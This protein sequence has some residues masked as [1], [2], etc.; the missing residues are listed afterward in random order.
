MRPTTLGGH[1]SYV[2]VQGTSMEPTYHDGDLVIVREDEHYAIGDIIAFRAGGQFDDPTRV[3]HR[4]VGQADAGAFVTR[5]DNRDSTDPWEPKPDHIIGRAIFHVPRVGAWAVQAGRPEVLAALGGGAVFLGDRKRRRRRRH[6]TATPDGELPRTTELPPRPAR[7]A[8]AIPSRW[9][10]HTEPRWAFVGF[11]ASAL[12]AL[13]LLV[14]TWSAINADDASTKVEHLADIDFGIGFDYRFVGDP[15]TVYPSGGVSTKQDPA[16]LL[17]PTGPLYTRLLHRLELA[18]SFRSGS[19]GTDTLTASY[20]VDVTASMPEGWS[21]SLVAIAPVSFEDST[22]KVLAVDLD[23]VAARVAEVAA[24]TGVDPASYTLTVAPRLEV[25][26]A[27][28]KATASDSLTPQVTFIVNDAVIEAQPMRAA[29]GSRALEREVRTDA[30]YH[31]GPVSVR[32]QAARAVLGGLLLV[33]LA[34]T[35]WFASVLFGGV[36]LA[37]SERIAVRYRSQMVD[38]TVATAPPGPVVMVGAIDELVRLARVEQ[39]V[40]LHEAL[41]DGCHRYRV[42][43]GTVTYEYETVPEHG[44]AA[45]DE[46]PGGELAAPE[47]NQPEP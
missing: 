19:E 12:L 31:V 39:T 27:R 7:P 29:S 10:R 11:V 33:L 35:A 44:G 38:V 45:S 18:M 2:V 15:S 14:G 21:T 16:G 1:E 46:L 34:A 13:P 36:G 22:E 20:A 25:E 26:G 8:T 24:L 6:V 5:G 28:G 42:F 30:R 23:D 41:H 17:V 43:L 3:I 32:T 37:E 47:S 9:L 40:V 4:I